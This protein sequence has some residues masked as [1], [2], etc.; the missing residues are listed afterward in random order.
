[1]SDDGEREPLGDIAR[2]VAERRKRR[3]RR[4]NPERRGDADDLFESTFGDAGDGEL[5]DEEL[6]ER[7]AA[8][9]GVTAPVVEVD[10]DEDD[11]RDVRTVPSRLCHG[12]PHFA[13]PP[14]M[15]CTH[16][17]T[18]IVERVDDEHFCVADCPMVDG[19]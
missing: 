3:E 12:C 4:R 9:D 17:G 1:M 6:W 2:E 19:P 14:E 7:L 11:D 13:D 16:E 15:A 10:V 18:E 8:D 5:D